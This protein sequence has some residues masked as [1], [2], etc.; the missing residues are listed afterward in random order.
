MVPRTRIIC[1]REVQKSLKESV[2]L[3]I[4]DKI[5][6]FK[7]PG[8]RVLSDHII[9]PDNGLMLFQGMQDHT[10]ESIK[11]LEG[12]DVGYVEEAQTMTARSLEML[13]PTIRKPGSE[14]WFSWNPRNAIDPVDALLRGPEPPP[15]SIVVQANYSDNPFLPKEL[16]AEREF[17]ERTNPV[18]YGHVWL[19]EY[20]PA[21]VGAIFDRVTIHNNRRSEAPR[22]QRIVVAV[23]PAISAEARSDETGIVVCGVG[24]DGRGYVLGDYSVKG[25]PEEWARAAIAAFDLHD[26]D[27]IVAEVNQG[28]DMVK[29]TIHAVRKSVRVIE[30]RATRGKHLRAEPISALYSI[31]KVSHVGAFPKL[32]AQMCLITA[33]GYEGDG[34]PDRAD[35]MVYGMTEL[36]PKVTRRVREKDNLPP[37][38]QNSSYNPHR[39]RIAARGG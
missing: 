17:D 25:A 37:T 6:R 19:G 24:E 36:F 32:E 11:S 2:K 4:E 38:R 20:E 16:E 30:V 29:H 27:A 15:N 9:T 13:R 39:A 34:S 33:A 3:L 10:A 31:G 21:A 7:A 14:L 8:F 28:G 26:A 5:E 35:A 23:D 12:F 22:M 1:V 18:R